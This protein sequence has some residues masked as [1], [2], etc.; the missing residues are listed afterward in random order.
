MARLTKDAK[1][2]LD[3]AMR[4][5]M[6]NTMIELLKEKPLE[7]ITISDVAARMQVSSVTIYNYYTNRQLLIRDTFRTTRDAV[8]HKLCEVQNTPGN[9][10]ERLLELA[11]II[12]ED[13]EENHFL[14][15]ARFSNPPLDPEG[16]KEAR[17][18]FQELLTIFTR[19]ISRGIDEKIFR[20]VDPEKTAIMM[21]GAVMGLN[22]HCLFGWVDM[23][24]DSRLDSF[25]DF[26][27]KGLLVSPQKQ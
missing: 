2:A 23:E 5:S 9:P 3:K 7:Q 22:R 19:E 24:I 8:Y 14:F 20:P 18:Q 15:M 6:R 21:L 27:I 11:R 13:F 12:F 17:N 25:N 4:D 16:K 26:L 1:A 10:A